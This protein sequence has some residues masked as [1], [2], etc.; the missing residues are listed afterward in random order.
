MPERKRPTTNEVWSYINSQKANT[1]DVSSIQPQE[2]NLSDIETTTVINQFKE[3]KIQENGETSKEIFQATSATFI[4]MEQINLNNQIQSID[5]IESDKISCNS[6]DSIVEKISTID[7]KD[8]LIE[9]LQS[10]L[11]EKCKRE[12]ELSLE[13]ERLKNLLK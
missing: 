2:Q 10:Q 13:V 5:V 1:N 11:F 7:D 12:S 9:F 3:I 8:K 6:N 4:E